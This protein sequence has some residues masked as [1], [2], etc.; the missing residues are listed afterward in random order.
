M[1]RGATGLRQ[2]DLCCGLPFMLFI[3]VSS[4][5]WKF[6]Q[7]VVLVQ[8]LESQVWDACSAPSGWVPS[9]LDRCVFL[10]CALLQWSAPS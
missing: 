3:S 4:A 7:T 10:V 9:W 2:A 6:S 8:D 5:E 1:A